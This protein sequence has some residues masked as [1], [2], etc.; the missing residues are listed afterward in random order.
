MIQFDWKGA[1]LK[2]FLKKRG[3]SVKGAAEMLGVSRQTVYQ[4]F[5]SD[6]LTREVVNKI[7]TTFSSLESEIFEAVAISGSENI[8]F[9]NVAVGIKSKPI[10]SNGVKNGFQNDFI[11]LH[12]GNLLLVTPL[13]EGYLRDKFLN[14]LLNNNLMLSDF[15]SQS[16]I[17]DKFQK[18]EFLSFRVVGSSMDDGTSQ[19]ILAG[20]I[21]TGQKMEL[22][23]LKN[24]FSFPKNEDFVIVHKEGILIKR[25]SNF[26]P[27][28][29]QIHCRALNPDKENFPD[30]VLN[31]QDCLM[32]FLIVNVSVSRS[33]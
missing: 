33:K 28:T 26:E 17:V 18:G 31:V 25:I 29:G 9:E 19:S 24:R 20:S 14:Q 2:A 21:V 12:N 22:D 27:E 13:I 30:H 4:Y 7:L 15:P 8:V 3:I 23:L 6:Q 5:N 10:I 16:I 1:R 11:D 32:I